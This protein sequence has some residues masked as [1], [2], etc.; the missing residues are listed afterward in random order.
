MQT[1]DLTPFLACPALALLALTGGCHSG[2]L[3]RSAAKAKLEKAAKDEKESM[4]SIIMLKVGRVS[5]NCSGSRDYDPVGADPN[6]S[7]LAEAGYISIRK[8][9]TY[10]SEVQLT[11]R[12]RQA[13]G[14]KYGHTQ[15]ADCDSWQVNI[16]LTQY[17][18][19]EVTGIVE[20]KLQARVDCAYRKYRTE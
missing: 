11:E 2:H 15:K 8:I 5:G 7:V 20:E 13:V 14:D 4:A 17:D 9:T 16:P 19:L 1:K 12:G 10:L 6:Y 18:H 3:T